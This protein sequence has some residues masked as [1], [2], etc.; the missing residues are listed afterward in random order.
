MHYSVA[1]SEGIFRIIQVTESWGLF[2][3]DVFLGDY[4]TAEKAAESVARRK[5][6]WDAWDLGKGQSPGTLEAWRTEG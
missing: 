3:N 1:T 2:L 4:K 6:G 5:T